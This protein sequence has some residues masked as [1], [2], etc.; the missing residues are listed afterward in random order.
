MA[1]GG[2]PGGTR[3]DSGR[4]RLWRLSVKVHQTDAQAILLLTGRLGHSTAPEL[5]SAM[6]PLLAAGV[7]NMILDLSCVDYL[8][9]AALDT[10]ERMSRDLASRGGR[11]ILR[12]P[13]DPVRIALELSGS[14]LPHIETDPV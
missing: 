1:D 8:S 6:R 3:G 13:A 5:E 2:V 7:V 12:A 14:L 11:L 10:L 9:S 4:R